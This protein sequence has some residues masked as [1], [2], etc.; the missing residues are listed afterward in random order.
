RRIDLRI[1]GVL[2]KSTGAGSTIAALL[3][4]PGPVNAMVARTASVQRDTRETQI[5]VSLNLDGSGE[6][7]FATGIPFL[8]HMLD[9]VARHGLIDLDIQASGDREIDDHHTVEDI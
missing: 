9:Q 4:Q 5:R 8:D 7:R 1:D 2:F 6:G 3:R